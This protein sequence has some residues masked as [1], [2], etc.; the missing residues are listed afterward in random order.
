MKFKLPVVLLGLLIG[1]ISYS[2]E[3]HD[4]SA[5]GVKPQ[6]G[7]VIQSLETI[8]LELVQMQ[9][10]IR[11]YIFNKDNPPKSL[12]TKNYPASAKVIFPRGKGTKEA[13]LV[14]EENF[15]TTTVNSQGIHRYDF[16]LTIEQGGHKDNLKFTVE[17]K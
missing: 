9:N 2:H 14:A 5:E 3:G 16:V 15:W 13:K 7:G 4:H 1:S 8:H 11:I 12:L 10:K 17:P 6:K